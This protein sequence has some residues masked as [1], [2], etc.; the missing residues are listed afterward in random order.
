M[1]L[2]NLSLE[3]Q[4][5]LSSLLCG[6][7]EEKAFAYRLQLFFVANRDLESKSHQSDFQRALETGVDKKGL[8]RN[9][10]ERGGGEYSLTAAGLQA[11]HANFGDIAAK[12]RPATKTAFRATLEGTVGETRVRVRTTG[13]IAAVTVDGLPMRSAVDACKRI[14]TKTGLRLD[15]TGNSAV[16]VIYDLGIDHGFLIKLD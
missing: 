5:L 14:G 11:A 16:R 2:A 10:G 4:L 7:G 3:Q 6:L 12:Y 8:W 9:A 13:D 1:S 15:P